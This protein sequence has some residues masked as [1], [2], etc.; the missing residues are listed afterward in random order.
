MNSI[1][2]VHGILDSNKNN[3]FLSPF[4]ST[5]RTNNMTTSTIRKGTHNAGGGGGTFIRSNVRQKS[6]LLGA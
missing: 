1:K 5:P 2:E 3:Q 4:P 6:V